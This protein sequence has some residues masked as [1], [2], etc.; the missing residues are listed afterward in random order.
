MFF[1]KSHLVWHCHKSFRVHTPNSRDCSL[2][3]SLFSSRASPKG[4]LNV[5]SSFSWAK[6]VAMGRSGKGS[7]LVQTLFYFC[8]SGSKPLKENHKTVLRISV[9][10]MEYAQPR[11]V[12]W[13]HTYGVT[14]LWGLT[15]SGT[16]VM[17][18]FVQ[19][20]TSW[21]TKELQKKYWC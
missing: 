18:I 1:H 3:H 19:L 7:S 17:D 20:K 8:K 16:L 11:K 2:P 21:I 13:G 14:I 6:R 12:I 10:H 5:R 9:Y 4:L 15:D